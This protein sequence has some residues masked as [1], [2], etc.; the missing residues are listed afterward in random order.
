MKSGYF[1]IT[2]SFGVH[3]FKP[4]SQTLFLGKEESVV[5]QV[6]FE[7]ISSLLIRF[8]VEVLLVTFLILFLLIYVFVS[9]WNALVTQKI[10]IVLDVTLLLV[11]GVCGSLVLY[12]SQFSLHTACH[13]NYNI[14]WLLCY[15]SHLLFLSVEYQIQN[16]R[17]RICIA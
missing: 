12:M 7:D 1:I 13:E 5:N 16:K 9:N 8:I 4:A 15:L 2:P 3:K 6:D 17:N 10:A 11:F 14:I